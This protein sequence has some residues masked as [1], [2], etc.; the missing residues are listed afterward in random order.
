MRALGCGFHLSWPEWEWFVQLWTR[1]HGT[2]PVQAVRGGP[3]AGPSCAGPGWDTW[4][5][6]TVQGS[7]SGG[8][9]DQSFPGCSP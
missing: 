9:E 4:A 1:D 8:D 2:A 6:H 3:G 7:G 5:P